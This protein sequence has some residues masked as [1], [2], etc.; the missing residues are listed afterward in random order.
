MC[1][2]HNTN[3]LIRVMP[4]RG[5]GLQPRVAASSR[6][7]WVARRMKS[8]STPTGLRLPRAEGATPLGLKRA[9]RSQTQSSPSSTSNPGL[10]DETPSGYSSR[11]FAS[12]GRS[13]HGLSLI[14]VSAAIVLLGALATIVMQ[15]LEWTLV[16]RREA[17]RRE[18]ALVEAGN[19]MER[20]AAAKWESL[21]PRASA[22]EPL[23]AIAKDMLPARD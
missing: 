12:S 4:Q 9:S 20:L 3:A 8:R 1:R 2:V 21:A 10:R 16:E 11:T 23:S 22:E 17:E 19:A 15:A 6:L 14:E 18:I 7:P 13:R 5:F